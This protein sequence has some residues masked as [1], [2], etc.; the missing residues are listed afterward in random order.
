MPTLSA[1]SLR[2]FVRDIYAAHGLTPE[3]AQT[4][5]EVQ[6]WANL[7]GI[8]SHGVSRVVTY[9]GLI[10]KGLVNLEPAITVDSSR[11]GVAIVDADRAPGPVALTVAA[12]EAI[13]RARENGVAW[14]AVKDT[15]HTGAI[16]Y[17]TNRIAEAG[18]V[19]IGMVA[20]MPNMGYTGAAGASVATSPLS[21]AVPGTGKYPTPLLDMATAVI[22]LGK[23]AQAKKTGTPLPDNSAMT[24]DGVITTDAEQATIPLPM[25]G[26]KGSGMSLMFELL[27]S[28]L[29]GAPILAP[30][31]REGKKKHRQ[32]ASILALDPTAFGDEF[33]FG[34]SVDNAI[35]TIHALPKAPGVDAVL[36]PGDRGARSEA[37]LLADGIVVRPALWEE[38]TAAAASAGVAVPEV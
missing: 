13:R 20:G 21:I 25:S 23:I 6:V 3:A 35:E 12:D 9:L 7:R 17:Y 28:V 36:V 5:A 19:G 15:V 1:T 10:E 30:Y 16:G 31:H 38:L 29:V 32:N 33:T 26:P 27:T 18:L 11:P 8:D 4:L 34:G 22:A 14:V 2:T 24:D 37:E